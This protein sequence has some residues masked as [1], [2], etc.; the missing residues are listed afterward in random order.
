[1]PQYCLSS[2]LDVQ[3]KTLLLKIY[4][5]LPA[6]LKYLK[7]PICELSPAIF[8]VWLGKAELS[9]ISVAAMKDTDLCPLGYALQGQKLVGSKTMAKTVWYLG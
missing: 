6:D 8:P 9:G 2:I 4:D 1:M 7:F 5:Q 3:I